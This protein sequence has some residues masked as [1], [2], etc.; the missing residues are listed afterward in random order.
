MKREKHM[1]KFQARG[2][3]GGIFP[4]IQRQ[5]ATLYFNQ[6]SLE[7]AG[8]AG[9]FSNFKIQIFQQQAPGSRFKFKVN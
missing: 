7:G 1:G 8:N 2:N 5:A 4:Y 9:I 3:F 6:I